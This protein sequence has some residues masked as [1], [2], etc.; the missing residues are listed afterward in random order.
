MV[1]G[2]FYIF[3]IRLILSFLIALLISRFFF[4]G[5]SIVKVLGLAVILF[6]LAYV[7]EYTKK[8]DKREEP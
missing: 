6:V 5:T 8:R 2:S 4:Q 7:F 1:M 3:F